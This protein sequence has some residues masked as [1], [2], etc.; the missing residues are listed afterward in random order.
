MRSL[1]LRPTRLTNAWVPF[2]VA[3]AM[4]VRDGGRVGLVLPAELL[5]V[6]YAAPLRDFLLSNHVPGCAMLVDRATLERALP[7][8]PGIV[9]P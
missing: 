4:L 2:V 1:G 8:S 6:T 5:Q 3:A 9:W 7:F